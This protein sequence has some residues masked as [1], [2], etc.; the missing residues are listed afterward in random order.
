MFLVQKRFSDV[1]IAA[2]KVVY[3]QTI[4]KIDYEADW[5]FCAEQ[6]FIED[7]R[8]FF[9]IP[10]GKLFVL[11]IDGKTV[12]ALRSEPYA[13]GELFSYLETAP[14]MRGTG[15]GSDLVAESIRYLAQQG[16][17]R[18][19]AHVNKKNLPSLAVHRANGFC[20]YSDYAKLLDG[21]V[22]QN[23]YTLQ[24]NSTAE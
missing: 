24:Y 13:D 17:H 1:D 7:L 10:N 15:Y 2:L 23:Y 3:S 5:R 19:Y 14:E 16:T 11:R 21:T 18:I 9:E 6:C 12:S 4:S 22:S 8:H 20:I